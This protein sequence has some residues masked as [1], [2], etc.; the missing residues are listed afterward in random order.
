MVLAGLPTRPERV[1]AGREIL[2]SSLPGEVGKKRERAISQQLPLFNGLLTP[3]GD[4][5][6]FLSCPYLVVLG[7]IVPPLG[8]VLEQGK[9]GTTATQGK[10]VR[11]KLAKLQ[12]RTSVSCLTFPPVLSVIIRNNSKLITTTHRLCA[13]LRDADPS[14]SIFLPLGPQSPVRKAGLAINCYSVV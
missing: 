3:L 9:P 13:Q 2:V 1:K 10:T 11:E 8:L 12:S 5:L 6:F 14:T 7:V 4:Y